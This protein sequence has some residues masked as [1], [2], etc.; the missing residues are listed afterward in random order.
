[1]EPELTPQL[2]RSILE[3][4]AS[5]SLQA[6]VDELGRKANDGTLTIDE[7]KEY[8]AY[9]KTGTYISILQAKARRFLEGQQ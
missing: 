7:E 4:R 3:L 2:A 1:M 9:V 6:R 8:E 5:E